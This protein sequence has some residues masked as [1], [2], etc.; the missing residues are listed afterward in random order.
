MSRNRNQNKIGFMNC[1]MSKGF[2]F[3]VLIM[4]FVAMASVGVAAAADADEG[5]LLISIKGVSPSLSPAWE[6][7][8]YISWKQNGGDVKVELWIMEID[9]RN[10]KKLDEWIGYESRCAIQGWH[11]RWKE[12]P[13]LD[14]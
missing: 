2:V 8:A 5:E 7:V 6:K 12:N 3:G 4:L 13:L 9:G 1:L 10:L 11:P 14:S